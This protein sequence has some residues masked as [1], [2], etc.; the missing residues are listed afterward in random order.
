MD[1]INLDQEEQEIVN[2]I[3]ADDFEFKSIPNVAAEN[4]RYQR[5]AA[6]TLRKTRN[7]NIRLSESDVMRL[8]AK[9]IRKGLPYQTLIASILH[10]YGN[11]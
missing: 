11:R 2:A 7:V 3:E 1:Y 5:V 9:A 10:Q 8:K 6:E 4:K